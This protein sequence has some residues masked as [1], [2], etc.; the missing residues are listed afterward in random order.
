[1]HGL[2]PNVER[3]AGLPQRR[4]NASDQVCLP[5]DAAQTSRSRPLALAGFRPTS[6]GATPRRRQARVADAGEPRSASLGNLMASVGP[7]RNWNVRKE[8]VVRR[9]TVADS[10]R[11]RVRRSPE[12][13]DATPIGDVEGPA[14]FPWDTRTPPAAR[15]LPRRTGPW[16]R[17]ERLAAEASAAASEPGRRQS[18]GSRPDRFSPSRAW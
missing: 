8:T 16:E 14:K 2:R 11:V 4:A 12:A 1:M 18:P 5:C 7:A 10:L 9:Q 3:H 15:A 6:P 17:V 13:S